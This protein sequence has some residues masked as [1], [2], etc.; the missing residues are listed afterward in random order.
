MEDLY[1]EI[2]LQTFKGRDVLIHDLLGIQSP[3]FHSVLLKCLH[4]IC[5]HPPNPYFC[6]EVVFGNMLGETLWDAV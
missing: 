5:K 6:K 1:A 4:K 2:R 3:I